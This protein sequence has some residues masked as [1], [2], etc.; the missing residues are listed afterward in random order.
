MTVVGSASDAV[1]DGPH[2]GFEIRTLAFCRLSISIAV[3]RCSMSLLPQD[4]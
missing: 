4:Q 1:D 2:N 3:L